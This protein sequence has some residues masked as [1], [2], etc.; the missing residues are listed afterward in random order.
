M[1]NYYLM[2]SLLVS[3]MIKTFSVNSNDL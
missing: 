2:W 1:N 3:Q